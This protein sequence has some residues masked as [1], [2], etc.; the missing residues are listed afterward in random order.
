MG[1]TNKEIGNKGEQL[2]ADF[3]IS[4][5]YKIII[6]NYRFGKGEI[7]IIAKDP[8]DG[9]LVFVEVKSRQNLEYGGPEYAVTQSKIKQLKKLARLYIYENKF[10]E[11]ECRFDVIAILFKEGLPPEITHLENAF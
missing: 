9:Y 8:D 10:E 1:K 4:L 7:D 2:A 5:G 6:K 11:I 3:L